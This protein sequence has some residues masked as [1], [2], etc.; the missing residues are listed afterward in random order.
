VEG[1]AVEGAVVD[2]AAVGGAACGA[3]AVVV[4]A[5][6]GIAV[7]VGAVAPREVRAEGGATLGVL[8]AGATSVLGS[9][10]VLGLSAGVAESMLGSML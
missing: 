1:T 10:G 8:T 5:G 9:A 3:A 4:G 2:G 7:G 6:A